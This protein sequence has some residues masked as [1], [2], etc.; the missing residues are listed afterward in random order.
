LLA[1]DRA[2]P[3]WLKA[4]AAAK[5]SRPIHAIVRRSPGETDGSATRGRANGAS[6]AQAMTSRANAS[7]PGGMLP[8]VTRVATYEVA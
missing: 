6:A 2:M 1:V 7:A 3:Q 4:Y 8:S 5:P